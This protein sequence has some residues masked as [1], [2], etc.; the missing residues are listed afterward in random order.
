MSKLTAQQ[1]SL[2]TGD[3]LVLVG[4]KNYY[5]IK[6]GKIIPDSEFGW[7]EALGSKKKVMN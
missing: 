3:K 2:N 5:R 1:Y 7:F 6:N 4:M